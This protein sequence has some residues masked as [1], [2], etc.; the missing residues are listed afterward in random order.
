MEDEWPSKPE[1]RAIGSPVDEA[2]SAAA[3]APADK[4]GAEKL[5]PGE[6][7]PD[8]LG[9]A[10]RVL[11]DLGH[12]GPALSFKSVEP[13]QA[14][15]RAT[16][17]WAPGWQRWAAY[18][19]LSV[20]VE[21]VA[22]GKETV[23]IDSYS[24]T[25]EATSA[26]TSLDRLRCWA[27]CSCELHLEDFKLPQGYERWITSESPVHNRRTWYAFREAH[28]A[29]HAKAPNLLERVGVAAGNVVRP[30]FLLA[31]ARQAMLPVLQGSVLPPFGSDEL[32]ASPAWKDYVQQC[33]WSRGCKSCKGYN[34]AL[35]NI[36]RKFNPASGDSFTYVNVVCLACG[37]LN[38][39]SWED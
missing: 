5:G 21:K 7:G 31:H 1:G 25:S 6:L 34:L 22:W 14:W 4:L 38:K 39:Q 29:A 32:R 12:P 35:R 13:F 11:A 20:C 28:K 17:E 24:S 10:S 37:H 9:G 8:E 15:C 23:E 2:E 33:R 18:L 19:F 30:S 3:K 27:L 26:A 36:R 16:S